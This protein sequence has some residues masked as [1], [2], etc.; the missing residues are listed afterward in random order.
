MKAK[1]IRGM[2]V[3]DGPKGEEPDAVAFWKGRAGEGLSLE[4]AAGIAPS[5]VARIGSD[6]LRSI[7]PCIGITRGRDEEDT[8]LL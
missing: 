6:G 7:L 5:D 3:L 4:N 1:G 2:A 8:T